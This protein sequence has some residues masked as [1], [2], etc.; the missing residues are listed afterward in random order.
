MALS[1]DTVRRL[2]IALTSKDA[3]N[4]IADAINQAQAN[5]L[6]GGWDIATNIIATNV[7]QTTDFASLKVGDI[8]LM[9][10]ATAGSADSIGPIVTAGNLGQAAV[11]GNTYLVL[12][13][14]AAEAASTFK[15]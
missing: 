12:R 1:S 9:I 11:V 3:A 14:R 2:A 13:K 6:A 8:V 4:E 7:S 10:P 5:T 15:F